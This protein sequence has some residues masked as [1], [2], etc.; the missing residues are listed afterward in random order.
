MLRRNKFLCLGGL[1]GLIFGGVLGAVLGAI[2]GLA[3]DKMRADLHHEVKAEKLLELASQETAPEAKY[4]AAFSV[5]AVV[6]SAKLAKAD[7]R[8]SQ[9]ELQAF[10]EVFYVPD[11]AYAATARLFNRAVLMRGNAFAYAEQLA[12]L[13][14]DEPRL[15]D[16][17]LEGLVRI[18]AAGGFSP[19]EQ[20][21]LS[22]VAQIFGIAQERLEV[23]THQAS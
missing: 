11:E 9:E 6:L 7:G 22:K 15:L 21:F 18:A 17:L 4:D 20:K 23:L 19:E 14:A 3:I 8:V 16:E 13:F 12:K 1:L 10:H 5:G 2:C